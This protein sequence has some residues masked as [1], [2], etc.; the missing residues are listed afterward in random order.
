MAV[1]VQLR[2]IVKR[3]DSVT[4]LEEINLEIMAGE[5]IAFLGPSGSGKTTLLRII[6][7]L[8][9]PTAGE[10]Y[11]QGKL[12]NDVPVHKRD[13]A[14]VFQNYALF[15]HMT[16]FE[17]VAFG[18]KMRRVAKREIQEKVREA[19]ALVR[20]SDMESRYPHQLSGGQ[21]Q[22]VALARCIA[23][24]PAVLLLDEPLGALDKKLRE[25]MQVELRLLQ[26][27]LGI[28]T[29]FVTH[30]QEEALTMADRI[31]VMNLGRIEQVGTPIEIYEHPQTEFVSSFIG[32]SNLL[33]GRMVR[34]EQ[35]YV[36]LQSRQGLV[37]SLPSALLPAP[38]A[39]EVTISIRPE[40]LRLTRQPPAEPV[41]NIFAAEIEHIV[42]L[43]VNTHYYLVV[44]GGE[45]FVAYEQNILP[46]RQH[47]SYSTGEK[48][49]L[50]WPDEAMQLVK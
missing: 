41:R 43:G 50:F 6:A 8:I 26:K 48:V 34:K 17:N 12:V 15:T 7:G 14:M 22:R 10:V 45:R 31:A 39:G 28:T 11:I 1:D 16:V 25:T 33:H 5:F 40:K 23:V 29:V 21:Q 38:P 46:A 49:F 42:Y 27:A 9:D 30:D 2:N 13:L 19:L 20:L 32:V 3:Y 35:A 24:Q 18:L 4:A 37:L 47:L 36:I 44:D